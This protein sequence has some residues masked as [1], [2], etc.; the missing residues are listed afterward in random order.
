[1]VKVLIAALEPVTKYFSF[2]ITSG[3][4]PATDL[5]SAIDKPADPKSWTAIQ[6]VAKNNTK[7]YEAAFDWIPRNKDN[8]A[9]D[10]NVYASIWPTWNRDK[11]N[12]DGSLGAKVSPMPFDTEF[13]AKP[14]LMKITANL[15]QVKG[16][17]TLLPIEWTK[18][19]NNNIGYHTALVT[20]KKQTSPFE[21]PT[22]FRQLS[23]NKRR[24]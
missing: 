7:L 24:A 11:L 16:Y 15:A 17:I 1:M 5:Q 4:R 2:G 20:E 8:Y 14:R 10:P 3:I 19:E 13:W 12:P 9:D 21:S 18:G 23:T 6:A 22:N